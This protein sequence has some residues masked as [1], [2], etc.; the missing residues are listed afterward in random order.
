[1]AMLIS[2]GRTTKAGGR[3]CGFKKI[4]RNLGSLLGTESIDLSLTR[5]KS[6]V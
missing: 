4:S 5:Q 2:T 1:M 6:L 3:G